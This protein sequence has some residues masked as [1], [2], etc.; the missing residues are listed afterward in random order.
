ML[1]HVQATHRYN[2]ELLGT[3]GLS[4]YLKL[5]HFVICLFVVVSVLSF[6]CFLA[7]LF[8]VVL[9]VLSFAPSNVS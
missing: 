5:H 3:E 1:L 4:G 6:V 7:V 8:F 9:F 2:L